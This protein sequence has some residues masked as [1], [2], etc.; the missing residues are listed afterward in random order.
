MTTTERPVASKFSMTAGMTTAIAAIGLLVI[1]FGYAA[2]NL[3]A[4]G[5]GSFFTGVGIFGALVCATMYLFGKR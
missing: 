5:A 4:I 3:A 1:F 2:N